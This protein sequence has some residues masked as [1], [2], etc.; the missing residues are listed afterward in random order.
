M[1]IY[2]AKLTLNYDSL[3]HDDD[4][5]AELFNCTNANVGRL[6]KL[7]LF[8]FNNASMLYL[9][10]SGKLK[11]S[12]ELYAKIKTGMAEIEKLESHTKKSYVSKISHKGYTQR[13]KIYSKVINTF[14]LEKT[15]NE[16]SKFCDSDFTIDNFKDE[17]YRN[18]IIDNYN[19]FILY[20]GRCVDDIVDKSV[21]TDILENFYNAYND[22]L[23]AFNIIFCKLTNT[24]F[25]GNNY[26]TL[27]QDC[28]RK[29]VKKY[30]YDFIIQ[31]IDIVKNIDDKLID[32]LNKLTINE[33]KNDFDRAL[34]II[35]Q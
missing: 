19:A 32:E 10:K 1:V 23:K 21:V 25:I 5:T 31:T 3:Y 28:K 22:R 9:Y 4:K 33:I 18:V 12:D 8:I 30:K 17:K 13:G 15:I 20:S 6:K 27:K 16:F 2:M 29:N 14:K 35:Y 24:K 26:S 34:K 11:I 7:S